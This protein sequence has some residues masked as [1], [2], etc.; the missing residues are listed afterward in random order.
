MRLLLVVLALAAAFT[1]ARADARAGEKKAQL[2]T[3]CH[4]TGTNFGAGIA[5]LE[6]RPAVGIAA[7]VTDF[8]TGKRNS[9][10]MNPNVERLSAR[11][12]RDIAE[13]FAS[14]APTAHATSPTP[15]PVES[16]ER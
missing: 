15:A 7:A 13:Y 14:Q 11:D 9:P 12:I 3:L 8:K 2:C 6:G 1:D 16:R 5:L 4:R 10:A